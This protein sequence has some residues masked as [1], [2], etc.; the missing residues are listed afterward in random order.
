MEGKQFR[1]AIKLYRHRKYTKVIQILEPQVF[2]FRESFT[3]F[4]LLGMSCLHVGDIGGAYSYLN[5]A[6]DLN[7]RDVNTLLGLAVVYLRKQDTQKALSTWFMVLDID[8]GNKTAQRGLNFLK[9]Y[10]ETEDPHFLYENTGLQKI[11]PSFKFARRSY[12]KTAVILLLIAG[13][14]GGMFLT[15]S[16][17]MTEKDVPSREGS[18][19][20]EL[21][22]N[23][24]SDSKVDEKY[25]LTEKE[26]KNLLKGI[27]ESFNNFNDNNARYMINRILLSNAD[28]KIKKQAI[29][30]EGYLQD[31]TFANIKTDFKYR[32]VLKDPL[33]YEN[34]FVR[35]KGRVSNLSVTEEAITFDLLVGYED[36]KVLEGIVPVVLRFGVKIDTALP[37]EVLGKIVFK[38]NKLVLEGT[39]IHQFVKGKQ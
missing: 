15:Y 26:L 33:L 8:P 12:L 13:I 18:D 23:V 30:L 17:L 1:K 28:E 14:A 22:G 21:K 39:S 9:K 3:F 2:R 32:D 16:R 6:H 34:C 5:R 7:D 25:R 27:K 35:W 19:V 38:D 10:S 36:G 4:Y 37:I 29:V 31:S 20:L 24:S 11:M